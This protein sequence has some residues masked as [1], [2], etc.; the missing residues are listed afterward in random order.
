MRLWVATPAV[1]VLPAGILL[2]G[3]P[4]AYGEAWI[5]ACIGSGLFGFAMIV[6][7]DA[8][9]SY[10][11]DCYVEVSLANTILL[12]LYIDISQVIGD[13][14]MGIVFVRNL[15]ATIVAVTITYWI[16]G[17]GLQNMFILSAVLAFATAAT[18]FPMMYWGKR[19]RR[20]TERRLW[21]M[22]AKQFKTRD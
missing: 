6:L 7:W 22:A 20:W 8:A 21:K 18:T 10:A 11:M 5:L 9:L 17:M 12:F 1:F 15:F 16:E 4:T 13:A 14:M 19:S 2:F 3:L